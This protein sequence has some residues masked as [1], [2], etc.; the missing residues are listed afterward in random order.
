M[1]LWKSIPFACI[2]LPLFGAAV[3]SVLPRKAARIWATGIIA[4]V[5][6]LSCFFLAEMRAFDAAYPY[7]MG[8][9]DAPFGN[10]LRAGP[11]EAVL[12]VLF[13]LLTLICVVG[14]G[15]RVR[16]DLTEGRQGLY[17]SL[18]LLMSAALMAQVYTDD[19]FTAYVFVEIMTI[20][21]CGLIAVRSG[22]GRSLVAAVRYM[23]MNLIGSALFLLGIILLYGL[24]GHLLMSNIHEAVLEHVR[25]G[26]YDIPLTIVIALLC[27]GLAAKSALF[28]FHT[29]VPDAYATATP[30]S[31][32]LLASLVSKSYIVVLLKVLFRVIGKD[33]INASGVDNILFLFGVVG[34]LAGSV[35]AIRTQ[36]VRRMVAWSSVAQIGYIYMALGLM[37][38]ESASAAVFHIIAHAAAKSVLFLSVD[39]LCEASGGHE[40]IR[41]LQGAGFRSP[42]A[43]VAFTVGALS[44]VGV[45]LLGGFSTKLNLARASLA[46]GG[47]HAWVA[48][49]C[50]TLSTLLNVLYMLRTAMVLWSH[51]DRVPDAPES[52]RASG[53]LALSLVTLIAA[54]FLVFFF[55]QPL[56]DAIT[57]GF[58]LFSSPIT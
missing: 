36:D 57:R 53:V 20:A 25:A 41:D 48:L 37:T 51:P 58:A 26:S 6:G 5:A 44:L 13:S 52:S 32:S 4:V 29:W 28:P 14:G 16:E 38:G 15:S 10:M 11:L 34:M 12:G 43:G 54:N 2:L 22:P 9:Y 40:N 3:C 7:R 17:H 21:G 56:M 23:I 35:A 42:L 19:L 31:S 55:A 18:L 50:L 24:T 45:P 1:A 27:A 8:H 46:A 33:C 30:T 39:K 47:A 49:I